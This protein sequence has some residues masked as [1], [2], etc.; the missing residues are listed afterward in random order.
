MKKEIDLSV[1][2]TTNNTYTRYTIYIYIFILIISQ[3]ALYGKYL[4]DIPKITNPDSPIITILHLAIEMVYKSN[5]VLIFKLVGL[6]I[7]FTYVSSTISN[8]INEIVFNIVG[9]HQASQ[10]Y[11]QYYNK[12]HKED[13]KKLHRT[14]AVALIVAII[15]LFVNGF[16][17]L[18]KTIFNLP[19]LSMLV[20]VILQSWLLKFKRAKQHPNGYLY[21]I[22]LEYHPLR[23]LFYALIILATILLYIIFTSILPTIISSQ[24]KS[25]NENYKTITNF[26]QDLDKNENFYSYKEKMLE[27]ISNSPKLSVFS[28]KLTDYSIIDSIATSNTK[29]LNIRNIPSINSTIIGKIHLDDFYPILTNYNNEWYKIDFQGKLGWVNSK[30]V[31]TTKRDNELTN[32]GLLK[33]LLMVLL[34]SIANSIIIPIIIF[35]TNTSLLKTSMISIISSVLSYYSEVSLTKL[36][37]SIQSTELIVILIGIMTSLIVSLLFINSIATHHKESLDKPEYTFKETSSFKSR[38]EKAYK[39]RH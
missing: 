4:N 33:T 22:H 12:S 9:D 19:I 5:Q 14:G 27:Y 23:T 36:F 11:I 28:Y 35:V 21:G 26:R 32:N 13:T 17:Q 18:N 31:V 37:P 24:D 2:T 39:N 29:N 7:A 3:L 16:P 1:I 8:F 30:F 15:I 20:I 10:E 38:L 34:F 25:F 6:V